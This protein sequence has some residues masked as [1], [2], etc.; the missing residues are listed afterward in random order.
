[1][2]IVWASCTG[3]PDRA[4]VRGWRGAGA[5]DVRAASNDALLDWFR[6]HQEVGQEIRKLCE[7]V[8]KTAR[9]TWSD[10]TEGRVCQAA[11]SAAAFYFTDP[12]GGGKTF[13]PV[14]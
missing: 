4:I 3:E 11:Q 8:G 5:V 1:M 13:I 2:T 10:S 14:R 12:Q 6:K 7:P 9:A